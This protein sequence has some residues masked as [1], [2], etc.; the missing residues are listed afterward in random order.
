M[1]RAVQVLSLRARD[2][3]GE[4]APLHM[5]GRQLALAVKRSETLRR[6]GACIDQAVM[7]EMAERAHAQE[8]CRQLQRA[9]TFAEAASPGC[10][11]PPPMK[12]P[13]IRARAAALRCTGPLE[14]VDR[15]EWRTPP[16]PS[17]R[18]VLHQ[19]RDS[20]AWRVHASARGEDGP[21][22][23]G[24]ALTWFSKFTAA[25][26]SR[27]PFRPHRWVGDLQAANYNEET[28]QLFGEFIRQHGSLQRGREGETVSAASISAYISALRA[29]R[30][31]ETGYD[32][33][34]K[35]A[36]LRLPC[37]LQQM[38]REDGP[39]G[40]RELSRAFTARYL[41]ELAGV[42]AFDTTSA[43]GILRWAVLLVGHNLLLRGGEFGAS[44]TSPFDHRYG[45]A[46]GDVDWVVPS[47]VSRFFEAAIVDVYPLKDGRAVRQRIPCFIRRV[48]SAPRSTPPKPGVNCPWEALRLLWL[49]RMSRVSP[50]EAGMAP[51]FAR[52]DGSVLRTDDVK[53]FIRQAATCLQLPAEEFDARALR[54]GGATDILH[55]YGPVG[56]E[57]IIRD[58][59]R[60]QSDIGDIYSR[61]SATN[62]LEASA[63]MTQSAGVDIEAFRHGYTMPALCRSRPRRTNAF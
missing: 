9:R 55:C 7:V 25:L 19:L 38:R 30:S 49:Q 50:H 5:G 46:L 2:A 56:A 47:A 31:R 34:V 48:S 6:G 44:G 3:G 21:S 13:S 24:T 14:V 53:G 26:P 15:D 60:W 36:N 8:S 41:R 32:L 11:P 4:R 10:M 29:F 33:R 37:V 51:L 35:E 52:M 59:G 62:M 45:L 43:E 39:T 40:Q 27:V 1:A 58:K 22:H 57:G 17:E 20:S 54:I 16:P 61:V 12:K 63:I 23:L 18:A 28:F 42:R